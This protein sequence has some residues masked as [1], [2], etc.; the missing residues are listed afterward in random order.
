MAKGWAKRIGLD[1]SGRQAANQK[2]TVRMS[3]VL[4]VDFK[5]T[6]KSS[7]RTLNWTRISS[8]ITRL[9][10]ACMHRL[11]RLLPTTHHHPPPTHPHRH[12]YWKVTWMTHTPQKLKHPH[13]QTSTA[14]THSLRG[15]RGSLTGGWGVRQYTHLIKFRLIN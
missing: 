9:P 15:V 6:F 10:D 4:D 7:L 5:I 13:R 2:M 14:D 1:R 11:P 3:G 12:V 8:S